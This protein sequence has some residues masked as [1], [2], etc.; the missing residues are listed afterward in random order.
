MP[1]FVSEG[2][3]RIDGALKM[4]NSDRL[5]WR[6]AS[7]VVVLG[8]LVGM[9][10]RTMRWGKERLAEQAQARTEASQ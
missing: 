1:G 10:M 6:T 5:P 8:V 2:Q 4:I 3:V 9:T 7:R